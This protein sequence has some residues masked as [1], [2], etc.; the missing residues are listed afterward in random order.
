MLHA[1]ASPV[2]KDLATDYKMRLGV[3]LFL[4]YAAVYAGF[5]VINFVSPAAMEFTLLWGMNVAV[6]YGMGLIVLA[7]VMALIYNRMCSRRERE[8]NAPAPGEGK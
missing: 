7:L 3:W 5:V 4:F 6:V 2:E 1:P 8:L